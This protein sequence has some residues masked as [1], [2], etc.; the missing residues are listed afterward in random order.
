MMRLG[1]L[2]LLLIVCEESV[3]NICI[4]KSAGKSFLPCED[5]ES[6]AEQAGRCADQIS[7]ISRNGVQQLQFLISILPISHVLSGIRDV[8]G[9]RK[10]KDVAA[11]DDVELRYNFQHNFQKL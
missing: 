7:L 8:L 6:N 5:H 2:S 11:N 4:P 3:A 1:F 9:K 10:S